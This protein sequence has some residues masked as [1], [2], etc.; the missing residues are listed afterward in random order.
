MAC[1]PQAGQVD[2][3][4]NGLRAVTVYLHISQSV[5]AAVIRNLRLVR[6]GQA[7]L[8][9]RPRR[10]VPERGGAARCRSSA[11]I[12]L[13]SPTRVAIGILD[14]RVAGSPERA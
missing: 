4:E 6:A 3:L 13:M 8:A 11:S 12:G 1:S 5:T 7:G 14:D 2:T 9:A 10:H